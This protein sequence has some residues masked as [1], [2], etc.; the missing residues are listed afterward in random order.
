MNKVSTFLKHPVIAVF[1]FYG[2]NILGILSLIFVEANLHPFTDLIVRVMDGYTPAAYLTQVV[3]ILAIPLVCF[4]VG[5]MR[6]KKQYGQLLRWFYGV[7]VPLLVLGMFRIVAVNDLNGHAFWFFLYGLT[8]ILAYAWYLLFPHRFKDRSE[9]FFRVFFLFIGLQVVLFLLLYIVPLFVLIIKSLHYIDLDD[10]GELFRAGL[11]VVVVAVFMAMS[12]TL[13]FLSPIA[14]F[15]MWVVE[16]SRTLWYRLKTVPGLRHIALAT[17]CLVIWFILPAQQAQEVAFEAYGKYKKTNDPTVILEDETNIRK[18]LVNAY[19][20]NYR[21]IDRKG[22]R[23]VS[24]LYEEAFGAEWVVGDKIHDFLFDAILYHGEPDDDEKASLI[25][26]ELFDAPIERAESKPIMY[27]LGSTFEPSAGEATLLSIDQKQVLVTGRDIIYKEIEPG[28]VQVDFHERYLNKTTD[29]QEIFYYFSMPESGVITGMWLGD[30]DAMPKQY[31]ADISPRGAAQAVYQE[32][33]VARQDPALLEQVGPNQFRLRVFPIPARPWHD[34]FDDLDEDEEAERPMHLTLRLLLKCDTSGK[35]SFPVLN[36]KRKVYWKDGVMENCSKEE[37][38]PR[39]SPL[40]SPAPV[41]RV[42]VFDGWKAEQKALKSLPKRTIQDKYVLCYDGSFSMNANTK[43]LTRALELF[44]YKSVTPLYVADKNGLHERK[45]EQKIEKSFLG[46]LD[47][48]AALKDLQEKY[49]LAHLVFISDKGS[50]E[51][52]QDSSRSFDPGTN[53]IDM[54]HLGELAP[55]YED[56]IS[57]AV[58][59]SGGDT[60]L[61]MESWVNWH[62]RIPLGMTRIGMRDGETYWTF[63]PDPATGNKDPLNAVAASRLAMA[64]SKKA[65]LAVSDLDSLHKLAMKYSFVSPYSSMICL[66]NDAQKER[67]EELS[68]GGDRYQREVETG[69]DSGNSFDIGAKG[70][71]EPEEWVMIIL[72][73]SLMVFLYWKER[74]K[75]LAGK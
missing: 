66:V 12:G 74:K 23:P 56:A 22:K 64:Q 27:T 6:F 47:P 75:S 42:Q 65:G 9:V 1:I 55:I 43:K 54:V 46:A 39:E 28:W 49:P 72:A 37:W 33:R 17:L 2:W 25:Y 50:Y 60:Y 40:F 62:D 11:M 34:R 51:L 7:E 4:I 13:F 20:Q 31:P 32:L 8:G 15:W 14:F 48:Y 69:K 10:F 21:Y 44:P 24:P 29:Q 38:F 30:D 3:L 68:E 70:V 16:N 58:R 35:L 52:M 19:L 36:E 5:I 53:M 57:D 67:L 26:Q 59:Q 63:F 73:G 71:P 18:G 41:E 61:D 45:W